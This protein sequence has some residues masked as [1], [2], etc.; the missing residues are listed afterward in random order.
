M[1]PLALAM[2]NL[3]SY[4]QGSLVK[5]IV[6]HAEAFDSCFKMLDLF[7][8]ALARL[9]ESVSY[10]EGALI[11]WGKAMEKTIVDQV[12]HIECVI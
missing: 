11:I 9:K 3:L 7:S 4:R 6:T 10:K 2:T 1:G 12:K 8:L 5:P